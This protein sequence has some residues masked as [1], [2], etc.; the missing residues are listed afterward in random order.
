MLLESQNQFI[1]DYFKPLS[2]GEGRELPAGYKE[3]YAKWQTAYPGL[4]HLSP[5]EEG[6]ALTDFIDTE[7]KKIETSL[8]PG[9][10]LVDQKNKKLIARGQVVLASEDG[11]K[12]FNKLV[13]PEDLTTTKG[14]NLLFL[15]PTLRSTT[16]DVHELMNEQVLLHSANNLTSQNYLVLKGFIQ[17]NTIHLEVK[18]PRLV[19]YNVLIDTTQKFDKPMNYV[20]VNK[21]GAAKNI[22]ETQLAE[23]YGQPEIDPTLRPLSRDQIIAMEISDRN[24]KDKLNTLGAV[25]SVVP[26]WAN[27]QDERHENALQQR[28][29]VH[30]SLSS[31]P[32]NQHAT[33]VRQEKQRFQDSKIGEKNMP[34]QVS[35]N[36]KQETQT[37]TQE[38]YT[39]NIPV[40]NKNQKKSS[41]HPSTK[42][43]AAVGLGL[44]ALAG[45]TV[46]AAGSS[47]SIFTSIFT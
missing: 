7:V 29:Q 34:N 4:T 1:E 23:R 28:G 45:G 39:P 30:E 32:Q 24:S 5:N 31:S 3:M 21:E 9:D 17:N 13:K 14:E 41:I 6:V 38:K 33:N 25:L 12:T 37:N 40:S 15:S 26:S 22:P 36:Q 27:K 18:T 47:A 20:F 35:T 11:G 19:D 16:T 2:R 10:T 42:R 46:F 43:G 44:G 8:I